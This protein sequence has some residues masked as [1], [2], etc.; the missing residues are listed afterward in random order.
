[1]QEDVE[2][3]GQMVGVVVAQTQAIANLAADKVVVTIKPTRK[4]VLYANRVVDS[5]DQSRIT[6]IA[7]QAATSQKCE[8]I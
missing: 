7:Q 3:A 2:F 6:L 5:G 8:Y 1:M 4:P